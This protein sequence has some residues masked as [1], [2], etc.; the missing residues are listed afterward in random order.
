MNRSLFKFFSAAI[1]SLIIITT[2]TSFNFLR[3]KKEQTNDVVIKSIDPLIKITPD[4]SPGMPETVQY[5]YAKGEEVHIQLVVWNKSSI[6]NFSIQNNLATNK[7]IGKISVQRVGYVSIKEK[8]VKIDNSIQSSTNKYPDPL[9]DNN[10]AGNI[11]DNTVT[12]FWISFDIPK[13]LKAGNCKVQLTCTGIS[14]NKQINITKN[15]TLN[16]SNAVVKR[17]DYP[18]FANWIVV[19]I[20]GEGPSMKKLKYVNS[21]KDVTPYDN[22]Y[23]DKI[24]SVASFMRATNQN[25]YMLSPQRLAKY[26][27]KGDELQIDFSRFDSMLNCYAKNKIIGRIDGWQIST[28]PGGFDANFIVQYVKKDSLGN[29]VFKT[30]L[31]NDVA[32]LKY[33]KAYLPA[34]VAHLKSLNLYDIYYQHIADEP[35]DA[36]ADSY[37]I[38]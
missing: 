13:N 32:V 2:C 11:N 36:N 1:L 27:Y 21:N 34:L 37:I 3:K 4:A 33:Y 25:V 35:I 12:S 18:W 7:N 29:A 14:D 17:T 22:S 20:A 28:R 19:D 9:F 30:G 6:K 8:A 10:G 5:N 38:L 31:P 15:I 16:I 26:S 23:W 24:C